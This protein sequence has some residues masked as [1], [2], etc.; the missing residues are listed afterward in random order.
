M[1]Q[2]LPKNVPL[3]SQLILRHNMFSNLL[4][5][6]IGFDEEEKSI[7]ALFLFDEQEY[8]SAICCQG[9]EEHLN[10]DPTVLQH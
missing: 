2:Y 10:P 1:H 5:S 7:V 3:P 6:L 4:F 9:A 8:N